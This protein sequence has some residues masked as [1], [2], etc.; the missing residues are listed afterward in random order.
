MSRLTYLL[1]DFGVIVGAVGLGA[2]RGSDWLREWR[3]LVRTILLVAI[4][5]IAWDISAVWRQHWAFNPDFTLGL[6]L[7]GLPLEKLLFFI[8]IPLISIALWEVMPVRAEMGRWYRPLLWGVIAAS[9]L[10]FI[11]NIG[12]EYSM[13]V[14]VIAAGTAGLWLISPQP[15]RQWVLWMS[16]MAGLFFVVNTV[17]TILPVVEYGGAHYSGV[18]M[19]SIP[20]E[21]FFY[22]F[23]LTN[24]TILAWLL[25]SAKTAPGKV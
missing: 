3:R 7:A 5:F 20:L 12:H 10:L 15:I 22:N 11:L 18:R 2:W 6:N 19:G 25:A 4:P 17:L 14:S 1:L 16:I 13:W 9:A 8:A 23:A 24:L 21:D